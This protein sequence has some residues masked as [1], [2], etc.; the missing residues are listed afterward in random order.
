MQSFDL[1]PFL[2]AL[3]AKNYVLFGALA[4]GLLVA[5]MKQGWLSRA[6]AEKLPAKALPV[7]SVALGALGVSA[8]EIAAGKPAKLALVHGVLSGV[9]AVFGHELV[10][11][12]ARGGAEFVPERA[13]EPPKGGG[14]GPY[15]EP[16]EP[17]K[18]PESPK[19]AAKVV[20]VPRARSLAIAVGL[21]A[22]LGYFAGAFASMSQTAACN[23][24]TVTQQV[25]N[26]IPPAAACVVDIVTAVN[27]TVDVADIIKE[28]G[29]TAE[30][31][32]AIVAELLDAQKD[33]GAAA[34]GAAGAS[35]TE[36]QVAHLKVVLQ[37]ADAARHAVTR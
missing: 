10:V 35:L 5:L 37:N 15:R 1:Q 20:Y 4:V 18:E 34:D 31:V 33:A 2:D 23:N 22:S 17:A 27:G 8:A 9:L 16:A 12:G 11:E 36:A 21:L 29:V 19:P 7:L 26:T 30:S 13:P 25:V 14:G 6:L 32:Y 3:T 24:P 28:C